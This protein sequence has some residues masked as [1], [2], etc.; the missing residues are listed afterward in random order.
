[1]RPGFVVFAPRRRLVGRLLLHAT[2]VP[3]TARGP[4]FLREAA[5]T[6]IALLVVAIAAVLMI[7]FVP[8]LTGRQALIA[9]VCVSVVMW[10]VYGAPTAL[11]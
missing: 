2:G 8:N 10:L 4:G 11:R 3:G 7:V 6:L 1:M 9:M 5:V